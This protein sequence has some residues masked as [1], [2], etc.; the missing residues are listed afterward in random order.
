LHSQ[1]PLAV[2]PV[3]E[4]VDGG[5]PLTFAMAMGVRT[6]DKELADKLDAVLLR[7]HDEIAAVLRR[8]G[9]PLLPVAARGEEKNAGR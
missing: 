6:G 1:E 9:I 4:E 5:I 3:A 7:R 8:T 2:V